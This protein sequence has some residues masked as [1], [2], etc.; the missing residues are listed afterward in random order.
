ME[1]QLK[2]MSVI[3]H[4]EILI[5]LNIAFVIL[6]ALTFYPVFIL[7]KAHKIIWED[8][9]F[10]VVT[11]KFVNTY[12]EGL[13]KFGYDGN[14]LLNHLFYSSLLKNNEVWTLY[15]WQFKEVNDKFSQEMF[16][17]SQ[18]KAYYRELSFYYPPRGKKYKSLY[19]MTKEY[20]KLLMIDE[21]EVSD[22][23]MDFM[24]EHISVCSNKVE[25][26]AICQLFH[27]LTELKMIDMPLHVF[28]TDYLPTHF[29]YYNFTSYSAISAMNSASIKES[30]DVKLLMSRIQNAVKRQVESTR[31]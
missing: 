17:F 29:S 15:L 1:E 20:K 19:T 23:I 12:R 2:L 3:I 21:N 18:L 24:E 31:K 22:E 8:I 11:W 5:A 28:V 4:P 9:K 14:L 26:R 6:V 7:A 13:D 25:S 27:A 30:A 16:K 10:R